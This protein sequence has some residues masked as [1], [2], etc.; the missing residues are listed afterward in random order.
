MTYTPPIPTGR[1]PICDANDT[2]IGRREDRDEY[3]VECLNCGIYGAT[4]KAFRHFEYLRWRN[5]PTGLQRLELL[6]AYLKSRPP[7]SATRLEYDTWLELIN[8][9]TQPG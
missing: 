7:G 9:A 5:D 3:F 6:A 4:R 2:Y 8:E 1:C